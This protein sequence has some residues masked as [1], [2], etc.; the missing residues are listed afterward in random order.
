MPLAYVAAFATAL[1][2]GVS[3]VLEDRAAKRTPITG[4][5]GKRA[6]LRAAMSGLYI[7]GMALSVVAWIFS[8]IA[9]HRLPLFA[10]QAIAASSIGVVVVISWAVSGHK[11]SRREGKLLCVLALALIAVAAAAAPTDPKP[12]T[13]VFEVF[14]WLG[15]VGVASSAFFATRVPGARGSAILGAVSGLSDGG[16]ALCAR[17]LHPHSLAG[18]I[19]DPLAFALIPFTVIGIVSFAASLQRGAVS[20]ALACQ[21]AVVTV[22]PSVIGLLVL[23]DTARHGLGLLTYAGFGATVVVVLALTVATSAA[24]PPLVAPG[25]LPPI[26]LEE[27]S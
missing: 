6:A 26:P 22:V 20:V 21:Q 11:P 27:I 15:V 1:F 8:L 3:A 12:V 18:L 9:L 16:M 14:I 23:G 2:Y 13:W 7:A 25:A 5:S 4:K 10:V 19:T 24:I 17:A